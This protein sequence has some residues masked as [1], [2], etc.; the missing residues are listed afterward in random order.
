MI[1]VELYR[2]ATNIIEKA[3]SIDSSRETENNILYPSELLYSIRM[4]SMLDIVRPD[5]DYVL[6]LAAQCQHLMRWNVARDLY[7][8]DRKG[9]HQWRRAVM[10]YQL[11]Q[12]MKILTGVN[13]EADD[14]Q[15]ITEALKNQG[16]KSNSNSQIIEDTACLVFIKWYLEPFASKHENIK[17]IEI[18]K[19]TMQKMS[20]SGLT[21]VK[22]I[23]KSPAVIDILNM[24]N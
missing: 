16:N 8:Y 24:V 5:N 19:K 20:D 22:S 3:H 9:Y 18:L 14:I 13:I 23:D 2:Q 1:T 4:L 7:P 11:Q 12:T 15:I 10:D 6:K 21:L 17:I